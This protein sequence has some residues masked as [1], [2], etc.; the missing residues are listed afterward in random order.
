MSCMTNAIRRLNSSKRCASDRDSWLL[1]FGQIACHLA[2]NHP[3]HIKI[4]PVQRPVYPGP[5]QQHNPGQGDQNGPMA[6]LPRSAESLVI[7]SGM[8]L[9]SHLIDLIL[10]L[11]ASNSII[12][13]VSSKKTGIVCQTYRLAKGPCMVGQFQRDCSVKRPAS[14][15]ISNMPAGDSVISAMAFDN[16]FMKW[17]AVVA[18]SSNRVGKPDPF[19]PIVITV[20]EEIFRQ[21]NL[22][23][24]TEFS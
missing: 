13:P 11:K 7:H 4:F 1:C 18:W 8:A 15:G 14:S 2:S 10:A 23:P 16:A 12:C 9:A 3:Q 17:R 20:L 19:G 24:G 5:R 6:L 21:F 22:E